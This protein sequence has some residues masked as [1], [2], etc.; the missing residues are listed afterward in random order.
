MNPSSVRATTSTA[1]RSED[2]AASHHQLH[3]LQALRGIAALMVVLYHSGTIFAAHTGQLLWHNAFRAGFAGV[4][5]FFVLSG[6]VIFWVH[7]HDIGRPQRAGRFVLKRAFRL[8]PVYWVV[9]LLKVLKD[10]A[11]IGA[12]PLLAAALLVPWPAPFI[13]VSWT[14]SYEL[15]FYALFL[16]WIVLPRGPW[17][18]LPAA[19]LVMLP[20][21][22]VPSDPTS[23]VL[24]AVL[25]F[26][27]NSHLLEFAF[28]VA[29]GALLR[30]FGPPPAVACMALL[31]V[32]VAAFAAAATA[33]TLHAMALWDGGGVSAYEAAELRS[34]A[35]LDQAMVC[36][37]LTSAL[38]IAGVVG[39]ELRGRLK[40]PLRRPL[41]WAGD[42]SY[43]LYL[44]HG[45]V[46][47][48]LLNQAALRALATRWPG[49]LLLAWL[50]ALAVA[51]VFYRL[52]ERPAMKL[53]AQLAAR[54]A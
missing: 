11:A 4:D 3:S 46:I 34:N 12:L 44:T 35:V 50:A 21:L 53:G 41:A 52:V 9:L 17:S 38:V 43:S 10:P 2:E 28:G 31:A 20:L 42:V 40:L 49:L 32:G 6:L 8:L 25:R 19:A 27:M 22:P 45:F 24:A 7:G 26:A 14:L 48:L 36:F 5:V 15:L 29:V 33:G 54:R 37:G 1:P 30:R 13:N 23:G 16:L 47:H 18:W 39:L 51:F